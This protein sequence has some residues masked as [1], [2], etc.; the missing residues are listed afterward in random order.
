MV[1]L[2]NL[3]V[4]KCHDN[5]R[6]NILEEVCGKYYDFG[7]CLLQD[8]YGTKMSIIEKDHKS[9]TLGIVREIVRLWLNGEG[10]P[11]SWESLVSVL[12]DIELA[13]VADVIS[14]TQH[15]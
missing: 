4:F 2:K 6:M 5:Q 3:I 15:L 14:K 1:N 10:V 7:I 9:D 12:R 13:R 8:S 11:V